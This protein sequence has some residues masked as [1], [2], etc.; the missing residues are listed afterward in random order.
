MEI[1][2]DREASGDTKFSE[3][4]QGRRGYFLPFF[5]CVHKIIKVVTL[6]GYLGSM[7]TILEWLDALVM[8]GMT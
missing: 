7:R 8:L 2:A 5:P 3:G 1:K 4:R 6:F